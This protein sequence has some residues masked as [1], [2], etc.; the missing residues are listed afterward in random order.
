VNGEP[1]RQSER[2]VLTK[3]GGYKDLSTYIEVMQLGIK[4]S[5]G[6]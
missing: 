5:P 6:L 1:T 4:E 2:I 3:Y